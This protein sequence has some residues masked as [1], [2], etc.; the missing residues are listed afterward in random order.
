MSFLAELGGDFYHYKGSL[1]TPPCSQTVHWFVTEKPAKV[2]EK[3]V[4]NFKLLFPDPANNRPVQ[5]LNGREL[6]EDSFKVKGEY[7]HGAATAAFLPVLA[8][9]LG[10][11]VH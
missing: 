1:T 11:A 7:E 8:L 6:V 10:V 4:S 9:A 3:M 5:P 2:T